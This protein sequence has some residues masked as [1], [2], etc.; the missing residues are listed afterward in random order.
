MKVLI[1]RE[2]FELLSRKHR[3]E[4]LLEG[5]EAL[6]E[7]ALKFKGKREGFEISRDSLTA[8]GK[9]AEVWKEKGK[10]KEREFGEGS[11]VF[12]PSEEEVVKIGDLDLKE[13][14]GID[15]SEWKEM[16]ELWKSPSG[17]PRR[18]VAPILATP[19]ISI[20][21]E[22]PPSKR[23]LLILE[24]FSPWPFITLD[25]RWVFNNT[26]IYN[27]SPASPKKAIPLM[28]GE[29]LEE[30]GVNLAFVL[31]KFEKDRPRGILGGLLSG[32]P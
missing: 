28:G 14:V 6:Y 17:L 5:D 19:L 21:E 23:G 8:K 15:L 10:S 2:Y 16:V 24:G 22:F 7:F 29:E 26:G 11:I 13:P 20:I 27:L 25:I 3:K 31:K 12:S 18:R 4:M 9:F 30:D 1:E 32:T